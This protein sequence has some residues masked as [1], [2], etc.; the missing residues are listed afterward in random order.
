METKLQRKKK[1]NLLLSIIYRLNKLISFVTHRQKLRLFLDLEW[2]FDRLVHEESELVFQPLEHPIRNHSLEFIKRRVGGRSVVCDIGCKYG[3]ISYLLA[4]V[5]GE[6]VAIDCD[7]S[8]IDIAKRTYMKSNLTFIHSEAFSY[9][10]ELKKNFDAVIL[11]HV[12]EHLENPEEF[13]NRLKDH[14]RLIYIEVPDFDKTY[15]NAYRLRMGNDLIYS[16]SDHLVEF[17]RDELL[18]LLNRCMLSIVETEYRFGVQR[19]W[20]MPISDKQIAL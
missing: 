2:I 19:I 1:R 17:N 9:L 3:H 6:V 13:I 7:R 16:D 5:S 15:L 10:M 4:Q 18:E 11:S 12:L 8:A 14:F 20:C